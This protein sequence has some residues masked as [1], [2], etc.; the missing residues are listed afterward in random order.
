MVADKSSK[1]LKKISHKFSNITAGGLRP[2]MLSL[3]VVGEIIP[4]LIPSFA[5]H[6]DVA[7][8]YCSLHFDTIVY[9]QQNARKYLH[10]N[11]MVK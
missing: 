3:P 6:C 9:L 11:K 10:R 8:K 7:K 5:T 1:Q 2:E 4:S